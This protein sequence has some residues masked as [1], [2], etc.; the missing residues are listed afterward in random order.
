M[1]WYL[2]VM[3]IVFMILY[4]FIRKYKD[5]AVKIILPLVCVLLGGYMYKTQPAIQV[6]KWQGI[7]NWT[8]I[9]GIIDIS[10]GCIIYA[11]ANYLKDV[12]LTAVSR[13]LCTVLSVGLWTYIFGCSFSG[14]DKRYDF[15]MIFIVGIAVMITLSEISYSN[16]LF[17]KI[18][19]L[20]KCRDISL[21]IYLNHKAAYWILF[22]G[23]YNWSSPEY[24]AVYLILT[25]LLAMLS[26]MLQRIVSFAVKKSKRLFV[27]Q[28]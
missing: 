21:L 11:V 22:Y 5:T 12:R 20:S 10:F 16:C 17:S 6:S 18:P 4:P 2:S 8:L 9:R 1:T 26:V 25:V 24:I 3:I 19:L 7:V 15:F 28:E 14:Y 27:S 13:V 23:K